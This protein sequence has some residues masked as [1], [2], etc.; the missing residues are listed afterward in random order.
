MDTQSK[1]EAVKR[2]FSNEQHYNVEV[3]DN[4]NA[5]YRSVDIDEETFLDMLNIFHIDIRHDVAVILVDD[6]A[7]E[8]FTF[9]YLDQP[10]E[11][12]ISDITRDLKK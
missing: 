1:V 4:L 11:V 2:Y 5:F 6:L 3:M 10:L 9:S 12:I 8:I 7:H